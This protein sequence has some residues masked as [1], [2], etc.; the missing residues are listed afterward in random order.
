MAGW[1]SSCTSSR[2]EGITCVP[3]EAWLGIYTRGQQP[4]I[5]CFRILQTLDMVFATCAWKMMGEMS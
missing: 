4:N 1:T 2:M 5:T 3:A